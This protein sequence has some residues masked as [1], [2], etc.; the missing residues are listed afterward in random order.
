MELQERSKKFDTVDSSYKN[1]PIK[2]PHDQIK[3][4]SILT[5]SSKRPSKLSFRSAAKN[6]M[7]R[8]NDHKEFEDILD[9]NRQNQNSSWIDWKFIMR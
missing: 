8:H 6:L 2:E 7:T 9:Q 3:C 5:K 1:K 4:Q